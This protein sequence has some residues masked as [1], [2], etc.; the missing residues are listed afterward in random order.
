M[1]V[2][3]GLKTR[4]MAISYLCLLNFRGDLQK[5]YGVH[6]KMVLIKVVD[7]ILRKPGKK[8]G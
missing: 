8:F 1:K 4:K 6:D 7:M 5:F 2:E 3:N